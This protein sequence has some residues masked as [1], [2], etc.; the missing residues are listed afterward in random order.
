LPPDK[1]LQILP[2]N[3]LIRQISDGKR[4]LPQDPML[5]S[6]YET[7]LTKYQQRKKEQEAAQ[8]SQLSS[9]QI[10]AEKVNETR[11]RQKTAQNLAN[12]LLAFPKNQRMMALMKM[13]VQQRIVLTADV[14][15]LQRG[16][17]I[18]DFDPREREM[19]YLMGGAPNGGALVK[20]LQ[21]EK[22]CERF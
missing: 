18:N 1:L 5:A 20:E 21:Q 17:L 22:L 3:Q 6:L 4:E 14:Q 10:E 2:S 8:N 9:E 13:P 11:Q 7:M 19:F 16:M 12:R 15:D